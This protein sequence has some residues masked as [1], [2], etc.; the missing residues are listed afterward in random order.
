MRRKLTEV[1]A[2]L[3]LILM[4]LYMTGYMY[5]LGCDMVENHPRASIHTVHMVLV[6]W[7]W[8]GLI[9]PTFLTAFA[10]FFYVLFRRAGRPEKEQQVSPQLKVVNGRR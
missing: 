10:I 2:L 1:T 3:V 7:K 8:F 4:D 5:L 6:S 9:A